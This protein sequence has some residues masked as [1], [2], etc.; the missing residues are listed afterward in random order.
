MQNEVSGLHH[1]RLQQ[2][3]DRPNTTV[4][5][6]EHDFKHEPWSSERLRG[7]LEPLVERV[8]ACGH[9]VDDFVLRKQCLED[10]D[11]LAFQRQHPK[12][13]YLLT[14]RKLMLDTRSRTA[15]TGMLYVREQVD[16]GIIQE[17]HDADAMATRTVLSALHHDPVA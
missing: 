7:V 6:V 16:R 2:L 11:V 4:L 3:A 15:V 5:S 17:G 14:D 12:F 10:A 13:Y 1:D 8:C 9:D